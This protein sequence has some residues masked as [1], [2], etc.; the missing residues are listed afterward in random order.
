MDCWVLASAIAQQRE[1]SRSGLGEVGVAVNISGRHLLSGRLV[2]HVAEALSAGG[3]KPRALTL[4]LTETVLLTDLPAIGVEME[5]LRSLGVRVAIDDFGTGYTSLAQRQHLTVDEIK[6]DRSYVGQLPGGRDSSLV[7]L[8]IEVG[9][10]LGASV[11]AEG[12]E[13]DDQRHELR[14]LGCDLLQGFLIA[15]PLTDEQLV[16]WHHES[17]TRRRPAGFDAAV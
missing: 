9:H 13:T 8:L 5:R 16:A 14:E 4:E 2:E 11:V 12:V 10:H 7:R 3:V 17:D 1:W 15:R 6:I